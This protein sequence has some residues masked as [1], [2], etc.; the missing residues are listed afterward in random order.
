MLK[1]IF[2]RNFAIIEQLELDF[3][4]GMNV[5][6]GETGT[7]KSIMIDALN[8]A[9]GSRADVSMARNPGDRIEIIAS[10]DASGSGAAL[11]WLDQHSLDVPGGDCVLRRVISQD[12]KSRA[13]ING[14]PC[15]VMQLRSIGQRLVEVCGQHE[16]QSLMR[17]DR[18]RELLDAYAGNDTETLAGLYH[19]WK[20]LSRQL[21][22][23]E[24]NRENVRSQLE[25]LRYQH[26]E[27]EQLQLAEGEY[28]ALVERHVQLSH[29]KELNE[30]SMRISSQLAG[31]T[32]GTVCD[33]LGLLLAE[34]EKLSVHDKALETSL[35][36]LH[37]AQ[38]QLGDAAHSLRDYSEQVCASPQE[39]QELEARISRIEDI[40]RKHDTRPAELTALQ[41]SIAT[42]VEELEDAREDPEAIRRSILETESDYM[43]LAGKISASRQAA[44]DTLDEQ[45]TGSM[46][47]LGM[48][49]GCFRID[50]RPLEN[51]G[52]GPNGLDDLQFQVS[53]N[54]G[55]ALRPL[56]KVVS[57]G[58]LSR[59]SLAIQ[60][61]T[62]NHLDIP[63][64]IFDEVDTGV[65][66]ATAEIVG[67]HLR[68]LSRNAQVFCVTHL[69]QVAA[70]A[71][72]H[73]RVNKTEHG[74][75]VRA[76]ISHLAEEA[77]IEE[78]ARMLGGVEMTRNTQEHAR[79]M[80][81]QTLSH[82]A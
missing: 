39:L 62:T 34:L 32:D 56:N 5:L 68:E 36:A 17:R 43:S 50:I 35:E 19:R 18:Q 9:L 75:T 15:P 27:L 60:I 58:E 6:T 13:W 72:H 70:Q 71:H 81:Q 29:A 47:G 46:Q 66:G 82:P 2:I 21:E 51:S 65:G 54:P 61:A 53:T 10:L 80:L 59:L 20:T 4:P 28:E 74:A 69:A 30:G 41:A 52:P 11:Q 48:Q 7:G 76:E 3:H 49:G 24:E 45:I 16:S 8:L 55:Q 67:R 63:T 14:S 38:I 57:G 25:L 64:L 42:R 44:A 33:T 23:A 77:R 31:D 1:S 79:E 78:L 37:V 40:A 22:S 12:G 26:Q 73:Y